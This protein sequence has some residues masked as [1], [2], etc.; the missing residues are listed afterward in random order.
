MSFSLGTIIQ[1]MFYGLSIG[2]LYKCTLFVQLHVANQNTYVD[3]L[4]DYITA[5]ILIGW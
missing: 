5:S 3:E 1:G 4:S 2:W